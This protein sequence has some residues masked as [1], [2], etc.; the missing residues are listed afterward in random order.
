M[1]ELRKYN[2]E[3]F[4]PKEKEEKMDKKLFVQAI[5]KFLSGLVLVGLVLFLP[6]GTLAYKQA[7]LL[8]GIL[9][10]PMFIAGLIMMKKSPD[11]LK[12][13]LDAKEEQS[14]QKA[15]IALSGLMFLAAFVVAGLNF[16]FGWIV[17][18]AWVS[19]AAAVIFLLAYALYAEVLRENVW[20]SR[21]IEVQENQ[22]VIDTGLYGIVRHPMYMSTL[23]LFL[24]MPL[25]L[26]SVLSFVIM[27]AYVPIIAKRIRN[28]EKVLESG[29]EGYTEYKKRVRYKVIPFV[30]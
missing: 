9:F 2:A 17:L 6:A 4:K 18:P 25:V 29:L 28:E 7:W 30:W 16:R 23:L 21:T 26:G 13:R 22:K 24:S 3:Q 15:V 27:L 10:I 11:L 1:G 5:I 20:L 14:E 19:L 12:K 8:I